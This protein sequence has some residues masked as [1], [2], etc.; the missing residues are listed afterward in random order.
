MKKFF[1][2]SNFFFQVFNQTVKSDKMTAVTS[3]CGDAVVK[4]KLCE[5]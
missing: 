2:M 5:L 3:M 4:L 1:P